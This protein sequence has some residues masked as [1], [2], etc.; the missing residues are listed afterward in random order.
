MVTPEEK[1][2]DR[3]ILGLAPEIR[4]MVTS[5]NPATIQ[6][7]V[8][9]ASRLTNDAVRAGAVVKVNVGGKRK[10]EDQ[11][12]R[13]T[14]GSSKRSSQLVRNFGVRAQGQGTYM[15]SLPKCNK[16]NRHHR[17]TCLRCAKCNQLGHTAQYC[18]KEGETHSERKR[19]FEC[20]SQDHFRDRCPKLR[21]GPRSN[22]SGSQGSRTTSVSQGMQARGKAFV[23]GAEEA[24]HDPNVVTGTFL[25]NDHYASVIFDSGADRSFV[26]LDFRPL[27]HLNSKR[28][29]EAYTI[30]MV[31]GR[32]FEACD[33]IPDC[34]LGLADRLFSI[35]LIPIELGSFDV[36]IGMDW[37]SLN[38]AQI[39]SYEKVVRFPL[40]GGETLIVQGET[41]ERSLRIVSC[42]KIHSYLRKKYLA[43]LAQVTEKKPEGKKLEDISVV[44]HYPEV[45]PDE[46][47]GLPP[48]RQVEFQIDLIP[49]AAP[50]AKAPYR[51]ASAEMQELS[52]QIQDLLEKGF[53]QPSSSPWGA[54]V[55]F[56]KKKDGSLRMCIDYRE[57][58][59]LTIK[60]HYPLPRIDDLFD[61]LQGASFFFKIDLRSGY[62]QLR[63]HV[64][65]VPKT[66]FRTRYGHYEFMVMPFGLT[67]APAIF[68]D[69]MNR[70][71]RPYPDKF[72]IMFI[73]DI[74]IYSRSKE[75]HEQ[76]LKVILELLRDQ[77]L[78]AKFSKCGF[79]I[80]EVHLLG[81]MVGEK[82]IHVD[83]VKVEAIKKWETPKTQTE[84]RQF[85]GLAGYYRK[86]IEGFLKIAQPLTT[87]TQKDKKF[88]WGQRQEDAFQLVKQMLCDAP[89]LA[90][91]EGT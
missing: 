19:C 4:G 28:L 3:Y 39:G 87:L 47:P 59:K 41:P 58:N 17:G 90:L 64:K 69:L 78:Y 45:F 65:D 56:V 72:V 77:K 26:S 31:D 35:D 75:D 29:D 51:L 60:N 91:P 43:F 33:V 2:I 79:W 18:R 46:L 74:L 61:Q 62:H 42:M 7:A 83:P 44:R 52:N 54:P 36:V 53:I 24:R 21:T 55:L 9:L 5:A 70:V 76:H 37:L 23:I 27:I 66:A 84:I 13:K 88:E 22:I 89:I 63:V 50:V 8:V 49:G 14:S 57:L 16:C 38:R 67:N 11:L 48:P 82:G 34:T 40:Q 32:K 1:R 30:E 20:G 12:G 81:H 68:M 15:G 6:S 86:F 80:R 25:L 71:C 85:L 10:S 73:D